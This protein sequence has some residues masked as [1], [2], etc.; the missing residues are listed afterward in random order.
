MYTS[1]FAVQKRDA[2][3]F[4]KDTAAVAIPCACH[5]SVHS[6]PGLDLAQLLAACTRLRVRGAVP[7]SGAQEPSVS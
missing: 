3:S 4:V 2:S 6:K 5:S 7:G 1:H